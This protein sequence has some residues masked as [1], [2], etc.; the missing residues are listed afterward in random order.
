VAESSLVRESALT[1]LTRA[2]REIGVA[3]TKA[4]TTQLVAL[5]LLAL[6]LGR[7][8]GLSEGD[9][10]AQV[11]DLERLPT[12]AGGSAGAGRRH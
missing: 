12:G 1:V 7:R 9:L 3:S 6:A 5:R 11:R 2:G 10:A 4:F 8:H